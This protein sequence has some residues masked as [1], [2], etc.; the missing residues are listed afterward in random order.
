MSIK[1][2]QEWLNRCPYIDQPLHAVMVQLDGDGEYQLILIDMGKLEAV[3]YLPYAAWVSYDV[4]FDIAQRSIGNLCLFN[5]E[6]REI[7]R[8]FIVEKGEDY[9]VIEEVKDDDPES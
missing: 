6:E 2:S 9:R 8:A 1:Q 7:T 4:A 3:N 5:G